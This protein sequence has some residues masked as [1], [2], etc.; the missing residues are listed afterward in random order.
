MGCWKILFPLFYQKAMSNA[1]KATSWA[2]SFI[3]LQCLVDEEGLAHPLPACNLPAQVSPAIGLLWP[4]L[5]ADLDFKTIS[6]LLA[7]SVVSWT[8]A[9]CWS[10][11]WVLMEVQRW[12]WK[13][14]G[15]AEGQAKPP[16]WQLPLTFCSLKQLQNDSLTLLRPHWVR[17][18]NQ[19]ERCKVWDCQ[20]PTVIQFSDPTQIILTWSGDKVY[21][22]QKSLQCSSVTRHNIKLK[23]LPL[24]VSRYSA[25]WITEVSWYCV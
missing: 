14:H 18:L 5:G 1:M 4:W 25:N 21:V 19:W 2:R 24:T 10:G 8:R 23:T 6:S 3:P 9:W 16:F 12:K 22:T 20:A 17:E 11:L 7:A 15:P 13:M